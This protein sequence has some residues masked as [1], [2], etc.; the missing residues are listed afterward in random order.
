MAVSVKLESHV[1]TP[2]ATVY[3]YEDDRL[4]TI[5]KAEV[6][7]EQ[8]LDGK[9]YPAIELKEIDENENHGGA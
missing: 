3:V 6:V 2:T 4:V 8:G 1:G 9:Y 7:S 5:V